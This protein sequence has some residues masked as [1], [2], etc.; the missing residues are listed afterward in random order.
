M[1]DYRVIDDL[2]GLKDLEEVLMNEDINGD[3]GNFLKENGLLPNF[4]HQEAISFSPSDFEINDLW[5]DLDPRILTRD[6][7]ETKPEFFGTGNR[8]HQHNPYNLQITCYHTFLIDFI[9]VENICEFVEKGLTEVLFGKP[10]KDNTRSEEDL[11]RGVIWFKIGN[12]KL[13]LTCLEQKEDSG[14]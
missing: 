3:L 2:G 12:D 4:D 14:S 8:V 13:Y 1:N 6:N 10:F 5:D 11:K 7:D 9:V